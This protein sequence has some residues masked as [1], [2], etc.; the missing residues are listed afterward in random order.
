M[1]TKLFL[2]K[3]FPQVDKDLID[4]FIREISGDLETEVDSEISN[5]DQAHQISEM[6]EEVKRLRS[7]VSRLNTIIINQRAGYEGASPAALGILAERARQHRS[8]GYNDGHDDEQDGNELAKAAAC[9]LLDA[10]E[11]AAGNEGYSRPP[12]LWPW[13]KEHWKRKPVYRQFEIAGA[14]IIAEQER[15]QRNGLDSL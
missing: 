15:R 10:I 7:E 14:L 4:G 8:E 11:R 5:E 6:T 13:D 3:A 2:Q 9:F 1:Y 12:P